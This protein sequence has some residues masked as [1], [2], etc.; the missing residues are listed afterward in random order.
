MD[1]ETGTVYSEADKTK[2][3][4]FFK[5]AEQ[6]AASRNYDYAIELFIN[7]LTCW[8]EAVEDGHQKLRLVGV[9]RRAAG[10]KKPGMMEAVKTPMTGKDLLKAMLNAE[11]LLAKDPSN[12]GYMEGLLKNAVKLNL[13]DTIMWLVAFMFEEVLGEKKVHAGRY[14]L[15]RDALAQAADIYDARG[16]VET[17]VNAMQRAANV[18]EMLIR[19]RPHDLE[20]SNTLRDTSSKLTILKGKYGSGESFRDSIQDADSQKQ[21][22]DQDRLVQSRDKL[23]EMIDQAKKAMAEEPEEMSRINVLVDL[24][25]QKEDYSRENEAVQILEDAYQRLDNYRLK[26]RA[27]DI[28]LRQLK[29]RYRELQPAGDDQALAELRKKRMTFELRVFQERMEVYPT[30]LRIK[31]QYG[32]RLFATGRFDEAIPILQDAKVDPKSRLNCA[33][34][35]GRCFLE[36]EYLGPAVDTFREGIEMHEIKGDDISKELHYWLGRAFE[37]DQEP[38]EAMKVYSQLIQWD[39]NYRDVRNRLDAL[40]KK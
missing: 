4:T 10:G 13:A 23:T 28:R 24:L 35:I 29:R 12:L 20:V 36:K 26:H 37:A 7:G 14:F 34:L 31:Y 15:I 17:A 21:F 19:H 40:R 38:E 18:M 39:F 22:Y 8:P 5:R 25:T 9:Q 27:D 1:T 30:D 11:H 2:A 32:E 16:E 3:R 33:V 6:A